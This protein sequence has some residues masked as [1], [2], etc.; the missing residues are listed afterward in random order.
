MTNHDSNRIEYL[1]TESEPKFF[2]VGIGASAGGLQALEEFFDN[3]SVDSGA[4]F[5]VIQH[6]SPDF[7]SLMQELLQRRTSMV[8]QRVTDGMALEPNSVY[9]IPPGKNLMVTDS[10]LRLSKRED[11]NHSGVNFPI[12]LFFESLATNYGERAIGVIL[13]GSGSDG[14]HGLRRI[15]EAGGVTLVQ[16]AIT[17]EFDG[18]P[19]S[20]IATGVVNQVL[21]PRELA[22]LIYEY[23]LQPLNNPGINLDSNQL[24]D[25]TKFKQILDLI[26]AEEGLDFSHYKPTTLSRRI[27]RRCLINKCRSIQDYFHSLQTS[28]EERRI[29]CS[30]LLISVTNFFR[31]EKAWEHLE[32]NVIPLLIEKIQLHEELRLWVTAC[33]TGEEAYSLAILFDEA[34]TNYNKQLKVKIFATDLDRV[35]LE[36]ASQGFYPATI[37][38]HVTPERLRKYFVAKDDGFEVVRKIREMLIF[39]PHDLTKDAGF[40]KMHLITC[41]NVL[42]YMQPSLQ[43]QVLRNLHFSLVPKGILFLGEAETLGEFEDEFIILEK[44]WKIYQKR[45]NIRLPLPIQGLNRTRRISPVQNLFQS[46]VQSRREPRLEKALTVL[47]QQQKATCLLVDHKYDALELFDDLA[48]VLQLPKGQLTKEVVKLVIPSLQLPLNA[49]LRRAKKEKQSVLYTNIRLDDSATPRHVT[50]KVDFYQ[51]NKLAGDFFLVTIQEEKTVSMPKIEGEQFEAGSEAQRRIWELEYELQQTRENLQAL[52]EEL[53]TTNEEHQASN[54]ELIAS[55]EELQSTNEELHS[56]NEELHTVNIEYQSKI[57]ELIE[58]NNDIDNLLTSTE[59]GVI[60]LDEELKIRKFTPAAKK[61][62]NLRDT[63]INRPLQELSYK[64]DYPNLIELLQ[65]VLT[66]KEPLELEV[67]LQHSPSCL[68]MRVNLYRLDDNNYEGIV[69]SFVELDEIKK[70][71]KQLE[72]TLVE[73]EK[74]EQKLSQLNQDL[75]QEIAERRAAEQ[76]LRESEQRYRYIY[77]YTTAMLHSIDE[78]GQLIRVSNYWLKLL[79]YEREE[80]IGRKFSEF[81]TEESC[82]HFEEVILPQFLEIQNCLDIPYKLLGKNGQIIDVLLSAVGEKHSSGKLVRSLAVMVD[83]T[84]LNYAK[85]AAEAANQAKDNFI[86]HMNHELRTPLNGI[87]GFTQILQKDP[88]LTHQQNQ[89]LNLI[90]QSGRH[91]LDLINDILNFSKIEADKIQLE[92]QDFNLSDFLDNLVALSHLRAEQKNIDFHYR[93]SSSLPQVVKA[94]ETRLR[95]VLLNLLSNAIK[96]TERGQ[97]TFQVGYVED[98]EA[99][100]KGDKG[101]GQEISQSSIQNHKIRFQIKDTGIGISKNKLA[102]IFLPFEQVHEMQSERKGTG[103]GLT[104]SQKLIQLMGSQIQVTSTVG[105]GSIFWFDLDLLEGNSANVSTTNVQSEIHPTG[106]SGQPRKVLIVDDISDNRQLLIKYLQPLGFE[107]AEAENGRQGLAISE[108][109]KP[110]V[111]LLDALM[112]E[113]DGLEMLQQLRQHSQLQETKVIFVSANSQFREQLQTSQ[114]QF[115][116]FLSKPINFNQLLQSLQTHL[117]LQWLFPESAKE[118][119]SASL[120]APPQ[121]K[122]LKLWDLAQIGDMGEIEEQ[123][124]SLEQLDSQYLPFINKVRKLVESFNQNQLIKFLEYVR[125]SP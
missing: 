59:I 122:L 69:V 70:V 42:I 114:L 16:E 113:M 11:K 41:R 25:S 43:Y 21:P 28:L 38:H 36:K 116:D 85:E 14:A 57:Q 79:G 118:S 18:M 7:K 72:D 66:K 105:E 103:L 19:C 46:Q 30:D 20:A 121:E 73:L 86:A 17:A 115:E 61:A 22:Q 8:V 97:V 47:L 67:K 88:H 89:N 92:E 44:K 101:D 52:V 58:L 119:D 35:A 104:I 10:V 109:F 83:V 13:S 5:V 106:F 65:R 26:L 96:F 78:T 102:D 117:H 108:T 29:L 56:V 23:T 120:V 95:Q 3:M 107:L 77:D 53:E 12:D 81:L 45:R 124:N 82:W 94:D 62:I 87:L 15:S 54:E 99:E 27:R 50:L 123:I 32:N 4:A 64:I 125:D 63:D 98:F 91:L 1:A 49:A 6:L 68:L 55:N 33:A 39:A 24:L 2:V 40:T 31:D 60:F 80:V 112:P 51:D 71:Q 75:Y 76:A 93:F 9:L 74:R 90:H 48:G 34:L 37:A 110:D 100:A 111:I 84:Q